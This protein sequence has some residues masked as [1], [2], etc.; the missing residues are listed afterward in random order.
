[1]KFFLFHQFPELDAAAS[2]SPVEHEQSILSEVDFSVT[3]LAVDLRDGVRLAKLADIVLKRHDTCSA[4]RMP[5]VS[6]AA[7]AP[8]QKLHNLKFVLKALEYMIVFD[9]AEKVAKDVSGGNHEVTLQVL[10]TIFMRPQI[11]RI[12]PAEIIACEI[13]IIIRVFCMCVRMFCMCARV[14]CMCVR[15]FG[16][17]A[18]VF[19]CVFARF[20]CVR[21]CFACM[22]FDVRARVFCICSHVFSCARACS[23]LRRIMTRDWQRRYRNGFKCKFERGIM[24]ARNATKIHTA[25]CFF[26][27]PQQNARSRAAF[28]LLRLPALHACLHFA[29]ACKSVTPCTCTFG[30]SSRSQVH[31]VT[32]HVRGE[33]LSAG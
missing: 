33:L 17:C 22:F 2:S 19:A 26:G 25:Q 24:Y 5:A 4:L 6:G 8:I 7:V 27:A 9:D 1:L 13:I 32:C 11:E 12:L 31:E 23:C 15:M 28:L 16:V 30:S 29:L 10:W 21:A 20:P 18:R 14:L 3:N